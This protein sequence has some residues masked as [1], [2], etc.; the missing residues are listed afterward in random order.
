[1]IV[2]RIVPG[3]QVAD[4][5][6][7]FIASLVVGFLNA[8]LGALLKFITFP[9]AILTFGIFILIINA[10]MLLFASQLVPGFDVQGWTPAFIG[11]AVLA[12]LGM[13]IR[14]MSKE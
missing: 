14:F 12:V 13:I 8:T 2:S 11:A 9:L 10:A 5:E 6:S 4:L 1:M 7:A 3:F